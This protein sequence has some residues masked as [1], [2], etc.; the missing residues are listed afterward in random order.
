MIR[1]AHDPA[2]GG[3]GRRVA[4]IRPTG[5]PPRFTSARASPPFWTRRPAKTTSTGSDTAARPER[6]KLLTVTR[7]SAVGKAFAPAWLKSRLPVAVPP[8]PRFGISALAIDRSSE[9][10]RACAARPAP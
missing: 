3:S 8:S 7:A 4:T 10:S 1:V 9:S 2:P 6:V 5:V